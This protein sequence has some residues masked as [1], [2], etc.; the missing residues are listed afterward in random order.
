MCSNP[1][2]LSNH[3]SVK[4][5]LSH[6]VFGAI[7]NPINQTHS[8]EM[9]L[10]YQQMWHWLICLLCVP[11]DVTLAHMLIV[12]TSRCGT[13][14]YAYC[15]YQQ[16]WRWL[17]CLLCVPA[18]VALAHM[19]IVCTNRCDTGSYAY[20]VYQQMWHWLICLLRKYICE[21]SAF[22]CIVFVILPPD[23]HYLWDKPNIPYSFAHS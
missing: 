21:V 2:T 23:I 19:L 18:D 8:R 3:A 13:C 6:T 20:C 1:Y 4:C 17:I 14:S 22:W 5:A 9:Y 7:W 15:V 11:A 16:M 12:C 10:W